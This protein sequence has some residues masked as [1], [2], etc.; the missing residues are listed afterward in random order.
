M[1][2]RPLHDWVLIRRTGSGEKTSG[3]IF[4]PESAREKNAEGIIEA[5][6]PGRYKKEPGK[7]GR[8]VPTVLKPGQHICFTDYMAKDIEVDGQEVTLIREEDV[9][10]LMETSGAVVVKKEHTVAQKKEQPVMVRQKIKKDLMPSPLKKEEKAPEKKPAAKAAIKAATPVKTGKAKTAGK[11]AK[12]ASEE[13]PVK[14]KASTAA[15][16][17]APKRPAVKKA[18]PG[19]KTPEKS[20]SGKTAPKKTAKKPAAK[21]GTKGR[22]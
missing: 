9:L 7:K 10:G 18:A 22:K 8:F 3:G 1:G 2:L 20:A 16:R 14:K 15:K 6:G 19:V 5:V 13:N 4:I 17:T 21:T 12:K 11:A